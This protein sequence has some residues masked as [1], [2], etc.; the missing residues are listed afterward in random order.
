VAAGWQQVGVEVRGRL[1]QPPRGPC[2]GASQGAPR[3]MRCH[4]TL[5]WMTTGGLGSSRREWDKK[6]PRTRSGWRA[7]VPAQVTIVQ[8]I[9]H[10]ICKPAGRKLPRVDLSSCRF[11]TASHAGSYKEIP[12]PDSDIQLGGAAETKRSPRSVPNKNIQQTHHST[13]RLCS[14]WPAPA[15]WAHK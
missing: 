1:S 12:A 7:G 10:L 8:R 14:T 2:Y 13:K 4:G 11:D 3:A 9:R 5:W 6:W 15:T